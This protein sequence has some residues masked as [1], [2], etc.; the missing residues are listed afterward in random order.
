MNCTRCAI[1]LPSPNFR[2]APVVGDCWPVCSSCA[3]EAGGP[4]PVNRPELLRALYADGRRI[5]S[6]AGCGISGYELELHF[7][8]PLA[9]GGTDETG[10]LMVLCTACHDKVHEGA[11]IR[12][13]ARVVRR[14]A[15][16]EE[17]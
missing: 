5:S 4:R 11:G 17:Q 14:R 8:V 9:A 10:N 6:C 12:V 1:E 2:K 3:A 7:L 15:T 16:E 13:G